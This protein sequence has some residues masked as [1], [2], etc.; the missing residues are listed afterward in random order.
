MSMSPVSGVFRPPWR[1]L[2]LLLC[3][4]AAA[5]CAGALGRRRGHRAGHEP[6]GAGASVLDKGIS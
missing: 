2:L 5:G 4:L 1:G 3:L 6:G